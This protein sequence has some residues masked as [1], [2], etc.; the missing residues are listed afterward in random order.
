MEPR[1]LVTESLEALGRQPSLVPG[2]VNRLTQALLSRIL[3][4]K[5][6]V[7]TLRRSMRAQFEEKIGG[8]GAR[9]RA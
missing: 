4:R 3:P 1:D 8:N 5:R 6:A 7:E 9:P 2:R